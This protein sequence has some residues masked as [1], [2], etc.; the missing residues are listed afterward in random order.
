MPVKFA[1]NAITVMVST[2]NHLTNGSNQSRLA[3]GGLPLRAA[4]MPPLFLTATESGVSMS[5]LVKPHGSDE[6][7]PLLLEGE[8]L[9]DEDVVD[10][11]AVRNQ[12]ARI[13]APPGV[14]VVAEIAGQRLLPPRAR[15]QPGHS[16]S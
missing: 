15:A 4:I 14:A 7:K 5:Q 3:G 16:G 11:V 12:R 8:A 1:G 13:V 2:H 10:P 6:L 9:V